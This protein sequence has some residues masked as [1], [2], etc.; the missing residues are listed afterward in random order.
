MVVLGPNYVA[1]SEIRTLM[2]I[3]ENQVANGPLGSPMEPKIAVAKQY[4]WFLMIL[5][6]DIQVFVVVL[7]PN[8]VAFSEIR[9]LMFIFENQ[10][11]VDLSEAQ[12]NPK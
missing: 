1:F 2:F 5:V 9:T 7:G 12:R 8:Y 11:A 10:V 3:F 6:A 4:L